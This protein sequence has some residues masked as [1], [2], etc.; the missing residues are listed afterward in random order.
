MKRILGLPLS[1]LHTWVH[2]LW[3]P[4]I[5]GAMIMAYLDAAGGEVIHGHWAPVLIAYFSLQYGEGV[6]R[7][8]EYDVVGLLSDIAEVVVILVAFHL[9]GVLP[10]RFVGEAAWLILP[11]VL[12]VAFVIPVLARSL[13]AVFKLWGKKETDRAPS[14]PLRPFILSVLSLVAAMTAYILYDARFF[15]FEMGALLVAFILGVYVFAF[16]PPRRLNGSFWD[17]FRRARAP[18]DSEVRSV[19]SPAPLSP[20][21]PATPPDPQRDAATPARSPPAAP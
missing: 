13:R 12:A 18:H 14:R 2:A 6:G 11:N 17:K 20:P 15:G 1:T 21:L 7:K 16:V 4:A 5:L 9:M 10:I 19:A 3:Y 8:A